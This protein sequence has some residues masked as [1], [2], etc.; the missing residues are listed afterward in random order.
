MIKIHGIDRI[1][2][3]KH[4][5]RKVVHCNMDDGRIGSFEIPFNYEEFHYIGMIK[6][7]NEGKRSLIQWYTS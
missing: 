7:Y 2:N 1:E 4:S 5:K 3:K 6:N